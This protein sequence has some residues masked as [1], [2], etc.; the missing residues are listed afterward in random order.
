MDT[1]QA[2]LIQLYTTLAHKEELE[3]FARHLYARAQEEGAEFPRDIE[4]LDASAMWSMITD[5]ADLEH[6]SYI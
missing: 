6:P 2:L 4:Y 5:C 1:K 3:R